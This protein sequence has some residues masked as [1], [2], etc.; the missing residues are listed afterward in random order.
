MH[1]VRSVDVRM[2]FGEDY[3]FFG[4][5]PPF[6]CCVVG[7]TRTGKTTLVSNLIKQWESIVI[8]ATHLWQVVI[9]FEHEQPLYEELVRGVKEKFPNVRI[10]WFW[11]WNEEA[12]KNPD[13]FRH[14]TG[15]KNSQTL[16]IVDDCLYKLNK[17]AVLAKICRGQAHHE[18]ICMFV[19]IQDFT[20]GG[21]ELRAAI[22]NMHYFIV[23]Q[24]SSELLRYLQ[25]KLYPYGQFNLHQAFSIVKNQRCSPYPY[26]ILNNTVNCPKERSVFTGLLKGEEAIL[27][28]P[29]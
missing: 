10:V 11:G 4:L 29:S 5:E 16:L 21:A 26:L 23:T 19:I 24:G 1:R 20:S 28:A 22:K 13:L 7:A 18:N 15:D 14:P 12:M 25:S 2:D 27:L 3:P 8:G 17:S 6:L 9:V